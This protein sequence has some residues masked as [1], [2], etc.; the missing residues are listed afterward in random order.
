V[1]YAGIALNNGGAGND[2]TI[3]GCK[4][5]GTV[6][7]Y[8]AGG[9]V[10]EMDSSLA[11]ATLIDCVNTGEV[12]ADDT[13]DSVGGGIA[14]TVSGPHEISGCVNRGTVSG[15]EAGGIVGSLVNYATSEGE[16]PDT[17]TTVLQKCY[18]AGVVSGI[19]GERCLIGGIVG[20]ADPYCAP[21]IIKDVYNVGEIRSNGC[22]INYGSSVGGIVGDLSISYNDTVE[23]AKQS[24]ITLESSYS[25]GVL[26]SDV[27]ETGSV[28]GTLYAYLQDGKTPTK[29]VDNC[30]ALNRGDKAIGNIHTHADEGTQA[31][32]TLLSAEQMGVQDS[33]TGFDFDTVWSIPCIPAVPKCERPYWCSNG[34]DQRFP[35]W[36]S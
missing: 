24:D 13:A 29:L 4:N 26:T 19:S 6:V 31:S 8:H 7:G 35:G 25:T 12:K 14:A 17:L 22:E 33:F 20:V 28:V 36:V 18:N 27:K 34:T 32:A 10:H 3:M 1:A 11:K 23:N 30:Y 5:V 9:I 16:N 15:T 2:G 21:V